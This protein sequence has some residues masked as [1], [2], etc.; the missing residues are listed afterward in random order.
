M[1]LFY[2]QTSPFVRKVM[3]AAHEL[4][5][6]A[7]IEL[8]PATVTPT[9]INDAIQEAN[10]LAKVPA[11]VTEDGL[12]LFD[13]RVIVEYLDTRA[14][15]TLVPVHG[16]ARWTALRQQALADGLLDAAVLMRYELVLRPAELRWNA[17]LEGQWGKVARALADLEQ[18]LDPDTSAITAGHIAVACALQY[19]DFRYADRPWRET[20]PRLAAFEATFARRPSMLATCPPPA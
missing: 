1:K 9:T 5:I 19:L 14:N 13:S 18:S 20:H 17:W 7:Q 8:V 12:S 11:L 6:V 16:A 15:G 10:P 3:V 4:G 2:A